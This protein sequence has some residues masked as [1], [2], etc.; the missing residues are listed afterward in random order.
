MS[1]FL[2]RSKHAQELRKSEKY[3]DA[4][5]VYADL[6]NSMRASCTEWDA[7]GYAFCL[8]KVGRG[9]EA[10]DICR[11]G[12][13]L[14]KDMP[15][16]N[17]LYAWCIYDTE[18]KG[19]NE[20]DTETIEKAVHGICKLSKPDDRYSPFVVAVFRVL[21]HFDDPFNA[22]KVFEWS[23]KLDPGHLS[24]D[25]RTFK[26]EKGKDRESASDLE[27]YYAHRT[28]ALEKLGRFAEC[29]SLSQEALKRLQNIHFDNDIW[30]KRRVAISNA[31]LGRTD[32]ALSLLK[33]ILAKKRDWFI[34]HEVAEA[35]LAIGNNDEAYK[36][37]LSA[38]LAPG[39]PHYKGALYLLLGS[40]CEERGATSQAAAHVELALALRTEQKWKI[41]DALAFRAVGLGI[42]DGTLR[43]SATILRDL[44]SYWNS[45]LKSL[46]QYLSGVIKNLLPEGKAGFI[47]GADGK[48]YYF[49]VAS[50]R[51]DKRQIVPALKVRFVVQESF[52]KKKGKPSFAA[53]DVTDQ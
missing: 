26:D 29:L 2:T 25:C 24:T 5:N 35:Y 10:L 34:Q 13:K 32:E 45:E 47:K 27:N 22:A 50:F 40:M 1:D 12:F 39:E 37:S 41:P 8:R 17:S 44:T 9:T 52:D 28:K 43:P 23:S 16:L 4:I 53:I 36:L 20:L 46:Q 33:E 30:F 49:K 6:W 7:W 3:P 14:K 42:N 15:Q 19:K 38:A 21:K 51:G 31:H 18:L 11:E 48:D